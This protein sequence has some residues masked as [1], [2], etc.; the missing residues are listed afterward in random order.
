MAEKINDLQ[1]QPLIKN[2]Q[3]QPLFMSYSYYKE[4][5]KH[6]PTPFAFVDK[7]ILL[8][9]CQAILKRAQDKKIRIA[10]KSVRSVEVLK[11]LLAQSPQMQGLMC[12]SAEE[13]AWLAELGFD[14]LLVAYPT[15]QKNHLEQVAARVK[16]GKKIILMANQPEHLQQLQKIAAQEGI[17][18][19]ICVDID[20][21]MPFFGLHFGVKRSNLTNAAQLGDFI[22]ILNQSP[23]LKLCGL[24]GYEAQIAGVGDVMKG[25]LLMNKIIQYLKRKSIKKLRQWRAQAVEMLLKA[26]FKLDFVNGGGTGSLESSREEGV[27]TEVAVGSGFYSPTLFDHYS[28]FRHQPAALFALEICRIPQKGVYTCLG[29]GYVASGSVGKEKLPL[30]C[31]PEGC[32]LDN[33]EGA[34]EVQTPVLYA[35]DEKLAVG[36]LVFFRHAKAGELCERFNRLYWVEKG[37]IAQEILTY[38][39]EGKCFV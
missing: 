30:P 25:R 35:G 14:D 2:N 26:G 18:Q 3:Q 36:D 22:S 31:L 4:I 8:A 32:V 11:F 34:G 27:I 10:T 39:G 38:R 15:V 19:P 29:G 5:F 28:N 21:S 16:L 1:N 24:M 12:Y 33:N 6:T 7:D 37:E 20:L 9:N 17:I 23:N 13:A